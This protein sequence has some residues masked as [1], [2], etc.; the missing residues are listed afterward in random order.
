M[1]V[2]ICLPLYGPSS[3]CCFSL[4]DQG[5]GSGFEGG[6]TYRD[7]FYIFSP[8]YR[9]YLGET[10]VGH[11]VGLGCT[12]HIRINPFVHLFRYYWISL[13][14]RR[15]SYRLKSGS[16]HD[17]DRCYQY[18]YNSLF[19]GMVEYATSRANRN[20]VRFSFYRAFNVDSPHHNGCGFHVLFF[21]SLIVP[22]PVRNFAI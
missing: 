2:V 10:N 14:Y 12:T 4:E 21:V 22:N 1:D 15:S 13:R 20:K 3:S 19:S 6:C 16:R 9:L 17:F 11:V 8:P 18:P 7:G 5:G